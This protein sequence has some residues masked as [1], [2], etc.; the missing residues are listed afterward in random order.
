MDNN[1]YLVYVKPFCKNN[2]N[3][4]EYDLFFSDTPDVVWGLDW[5]VTVPNSLDDLTPEKST[6]QKI[7]RIK[8][9]L[10]FKTIEEISC[11]SMEYAIKGIVALSWVDIDGLKE[12]PES[13]VVLHFRD[14]I[15]KVKNVLQE[16]KISLE[17]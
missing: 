13:R 9:P 14:E 12:F 1:L 4:Y 5:E 6:Y 10:P 8:S 17:Y 2:D 15:E 11:Y 3:T 16:L 7:I